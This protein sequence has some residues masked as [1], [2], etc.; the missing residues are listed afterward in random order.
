[1][2]DK[3]QVHTVTPKVDVKSNRRAETLFAVTT[4]TF[5]AA[6]MSARLN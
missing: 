4:L 6:D 2:T 3:L 1:M 5:V